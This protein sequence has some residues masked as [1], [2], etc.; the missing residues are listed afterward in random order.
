MH[1]THDDDPLQ[2][3]MQKHRSGDL[4]AAEALYQR[5][6]AGNPSHPTALHMLGVLNLQLNR[7]Q[8]GLELIARASALRPNDFELLL[9]LGRASIAC[10]RWDD[11]IAAF[12]RATAQQP[13]S[14]EAWWQ[15]GTA[16][17][18]GGRLPQAV[19]A[20][21]RALALNPDLPAALS[22]LG[23][24]WNQLGQPERGIGFLRRAVELQPDYVAARN[25]L[26]I[27][28]QAVGQFDD[29]ISQFQ[30]VIARQPD[31][32]SVRLNL[33]TA[34][35][36]KGSIDQAIGFFQQAISINPGLPEA[37]SSLGTALLNSAKFDAAVLS[38]R[39]AIQLRPDFA[40]GHY[41][42]ALALLLLGDFPNGWREYEWRFKI[43]DSAKYGVQLPSAK[44]WRGEPL[45]GKTILLY[46]EQG[47]GD[48]I[49]FVRYVHRVAE[50]GGTTLLFCRPEL[51][52]IF[53]QLPGVSAVLT[54]NAP[55]PHFDFR[56]S[57]VS[58]PLVYGTTDRTIP[59]DVPYLRADA[60]LIAEWSRRLEPYGEHRKI[61]IAWAGRPTHQRDH[62][63]S[64]S[65]EIVA[66]LLQADGTTFFSLQK[67]MAGSNFA[68]PIA[69]A[70]FI[71]WSDELRAFADTAA[72]IANL[73]LV[74]TVDTAVAHLAGAMGRPVWVLL[75]FV[76]DWRWQL[77]RTNSPWYPT[78]RL[79]RQARPG[80]WASVVE[81]VLNAL[82]Q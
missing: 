55:L 42:L 19:N 31:H 7:P 43:A 28:L 20:Y 68:N 69:S 29:A 44:E 18:L 12:Q 47:F 54:D 5:V 51:V 61:G 9:D 71:D 39:R 32:P 65:P 2:L 37:H 25:N 81:E 16:F 59:A 82:R 73:D 3:A 17:Q 70:N 52:G 15:M 21:E 56:C 30:Q 14:A 50:A 26:G 67:R 60:A 64:I 1:P 13:A 11:A 75:P 53:R 66:P 80:D 72:L 41:N 35:F 45:H 78:A 57:L 38:Y 77:N 33:G 40:E 10:G 74:I 63:R 58:L 4:L 6:L 79:F 8:A 22:N 49:Q 76:P 27:A 23:N 48:A 62:D 46:G 36:N 34:L 24:A